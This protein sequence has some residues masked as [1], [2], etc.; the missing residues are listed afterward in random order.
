MQSFAYNCRHQSERLSS[1]LDPRCARATD[2]WSIFGRP[3]APPRRDLCR[4]KDL[5]DNIS[6][7]SWWQGEL[8][9]RKPQIDGPVEG[10]SYE[11]YTLSG[12][13]PSCREL[14]TAAQWDERSDEERC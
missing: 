6:L 12:G 10:R 5:C 14:Q 7:S 8:Y 2:S 11:W 9:A 4:G 3:A 13:D 1:R